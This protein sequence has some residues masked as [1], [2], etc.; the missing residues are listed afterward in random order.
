MQYVLGWSHRFVSWDAFEL[1]TSRWKW[2]LVLTNVIGKRN[3]LQ[4]KTLCW[5]WYTP[6][7]VFSRPGKTFCDCLA[8]TVLAAPLLMVLSQ[9]RC[10]FHD[11][12]RTALHFHFVFTEKRKQVSTVSAVLTFSERRQLCRR[13]LCSCQLQDCAQNLVCTNW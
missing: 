2:V 6:C 9:S 12:Q 1:V 13:L 10:L 5:C 7:L 3:P 8:G 11:F 4:K